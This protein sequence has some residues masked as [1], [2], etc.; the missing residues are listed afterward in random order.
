MSSQYFVVRAEESQRCP[1]AVV[2]VSPDGTEE[3]FTRSLAWG[4]SDLLAR[5]GGEPTVFEITADD[6]EQ[7]VVDIIEGVRAERYE[8]PYGEGTNIYAWFARPSD[9]FDLDKACAMVRDHGNGTR[10]RFLPPGTW[11]HDRWSVSVPESYYHMVRQWRNPR[12]A[13]RV[14]ISAEEA[15]RLAS[16]G[17]AWTPTPFV[18]PAGETHR[19][20]SA[21]EHADGRVEVLT[22]D[23]R[24]EPFEW[25]GEREAVGRAREAMIIHLEVL[26]RTRPVPPRGED[27]YDYSVLFED[28]EQVGDLMLARNLVRLPDGDPKRAQEWKPFEGWRDNS[29]VRARNDERAWF[30]AELPITKAEADE[31]V[32]LRDEWSRLRWRVYG[33]LETEVRQ[34]SP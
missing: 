7:L 12:S 8:V 9:V 15:D 22:E 10:E 32:R 20:R 2:R 21:R 19:R 23:L 29:W 25:N 24:W 31:C 30:D 26:E 18:V 27:G 3:A 33:R 14:A 16:R 34:P 5:Y 6:V 28:F 11:T 13:V 17:I 1:V 4:P